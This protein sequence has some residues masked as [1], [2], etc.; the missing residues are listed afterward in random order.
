MILWYSMA[1][2]MM[3][4][5][6]ERTPPLCRG[7]L[8][9][10]CARPRDNPTGVKRWH[11]KLFQELIFRVCWGFRLWRKRMPPSEKLLTFVDWSGW[12][13]RLHLSYL[14]VRSFLRT[15]FKGHQ[16]S[17]SDRWLREAQGRLFKQYLSSGFK[18]D[19]RDRTGSD[20][21]PIIRKN[22]FKSR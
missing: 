15:L 19:R 10:E 6:R 7:A 18:R 3:M 14:V 8:Q 2:G 4:R 17:L 11:S 16:F 13:R 5:L 12:H 20:C 1:L 22:P 9:R 21:V